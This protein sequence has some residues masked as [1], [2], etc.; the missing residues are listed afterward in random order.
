[1]IRIAELKLP[2]SAVEYHPEN[3][4][5]YQPIA[6]LTALA[7]ERLGIPASAIARLHVHKRSFDAR[8]SA[9]L[10]VYIAD[11]TLADPAQ[12]AALLARFA[13]QSHVNPTPDMAWKPVGAAPA[14]LADS[15]RPVV[16]GFGPCGI[17]AALVL[18]IMGVRMLVRHSPAG[19]LIDFDIGVR[20]EVLDPAHLYS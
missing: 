16:V 9:L 13:D 11:I 19:A 14:T 15:E 17:F 7:A 5:E 10:A 4:T 1:M 20:E 8:K 3:H 6:K 18:A 2:L 12:E